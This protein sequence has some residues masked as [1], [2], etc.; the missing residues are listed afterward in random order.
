MVI[1]KGVEAIVIKMLFEVIISFLIGILLYF[2]VN[3]YF[4][5]ADFNSNDTFVDFFKRNILFSKKIVK[6]DHKI[7]ILGPIQ[8]GK[9]NLFLRVKY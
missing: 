6:S 9:T 3:W 1:F 8:S 4:Y 5:S 2:L 7:V